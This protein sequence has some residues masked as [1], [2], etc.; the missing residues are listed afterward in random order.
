MTYGSVL[1]SCI[2]CGLYTQSYSP[3]DCKNMWSQPTYM[4]HVVFKPQTRSVY[5]VFNLQGQTM[6]VVLFAHP[7]M[8][9]LPH[10]PTRIDIP[11]RLV[12]LIPWYVSLVFTLS[13]HF[14]L[15]VD[16][17]TIPDVRSLCSDHST[18]FSFAFNTDFLIES[19]IDIQ[20]FDSAWTLMLITCD[21][22]PPSHRRWPTFLFS[23]SL[24]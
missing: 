14:T 9:L 5:Y 21:I 7:V 18:L 11:Q 4:G 17:L 19:P 2:L 20:S 23:L 16:M 12:E 6:R 24:R 15:T 10:V 1:H 22:L 3:Y 8:R 13:V